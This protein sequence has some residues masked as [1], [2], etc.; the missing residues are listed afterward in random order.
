MRTFISSA[1]L[2]LLGSA[3]G[4]GLVSK[5]FNGEVSQDFTITP[6][7]TTYDS[8]FAVDPNS[9]QD[10]KDNRAKIR[11]GSGTITKFRITIKTVNPDNKATYGTGQVY[12]REV[13][14][15]TDPKAAWNPGPNDPALLG[16]YESVPIVAQQEINVALSPDQRQ[17]LSDLVF[18]STNPIQV[19]VA[20]QADAVASFG[21][22]VTLYVA[23][24]A[25][26]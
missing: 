24:T 22:T 1:A 26:L 25:G 14:A 13:P 20:G 16:F 10:V 9:N 18:K 3:L 8:Q 15:G 19:R 23:F 5:D 4:C 11:D 21:G 12:A 6:G 2:I 7:D 17:R